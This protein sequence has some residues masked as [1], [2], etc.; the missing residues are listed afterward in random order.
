MSGRDLT[1]YRN[2]L[3]LAW[4]STG[5]LYA[6]DVRP[7]PARRAEQHQPGHNYGRRVGG[8]AAPTPG[9]PSR[10]SPGPPR[11]PRP[12]ESRSTATSCSWP[13]YEASGCGDGTGGAAAG[14]WLWS[15]AT[16]SCP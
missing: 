9:P 3:G 15:T 2:V 11:M 4:D 6:S 16:G 1:P 8:G 10:W 12:P 7:E 5:R 14:T 13:R